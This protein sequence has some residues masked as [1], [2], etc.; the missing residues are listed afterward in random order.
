MCQFFCDDDDADDAVAGAADTDVEADE[1]TDNDDDAS[2][3]KCL[4]DGGSIADGF[5]SIVGI[6]AV[7]ILS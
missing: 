5:L 7:W 2:G 4:G 6:G 3:A 1:A